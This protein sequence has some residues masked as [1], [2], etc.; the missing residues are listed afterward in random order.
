M[1][2]IAEEPPPEKSGSSVIA[3]MAILPAETEHSE[4]D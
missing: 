1:I 2:G 4:F 3:P